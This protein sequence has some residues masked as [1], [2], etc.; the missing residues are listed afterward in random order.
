MQV[1][2]SD[3]QLTHD[4]AR[5]LKAG[6]LMPSP[7]TPNRAALIL[8][9]LAAA[10]FAVSAPEDLGL[11][12]LLRVH[13]VAYLDFLQ[14]IAQRWSAEFGADAAVL[15]NVLAGGRAAYVPAGLV[16]ALGVYVGD[17][18]AE[19]RAGTWAASYASAQ[20]AA[21]AG[22]LVATTG[23]PAYA[24]CRPPGHHASASAAM[25][26]CYLNNAAI[27]AQELRARHDRVAIVDIDVHHG[28]GTQAIFYD[29]ADVLTASMHSDPSRYYPY[30]SGYEDECGASAGA[31]CNVNACYAKDADDAAFAQA[32][33]RLAGAVAAFKPGAVVIALGLDALRTDPHGGHAITPDA[34]AAVAR[35]IRGW[36]LPTVFVQEGGYESAELGPTVARVL[37]AFSH[38]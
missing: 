37:T 15:P 3:D 27:A 21:N 13:P 5:F 34:Y 4:G 11:D 32:F 31:G 14:S 22:R 29:R 6:R 1:F 8:N 19:I 10:D 18:A 17:L 35:A 26:F 12:P 23:A 9:A 28:N 36:S 33:A 16:G 7:E 25:G 24:L 2:W 30:H 38:G 20:C